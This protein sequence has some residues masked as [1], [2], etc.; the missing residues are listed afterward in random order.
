MFEFY[1]NDIANSLVLWRE[2][3]SLVNYGKNCKKNFY[4]A[5]VWAD[6][7]LTIIDFSLLLFNIERESVKM[8]TIFH[9]LS[10]LTYAKQTSS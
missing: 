6:L 3:K 10:K 2:K 9:V 5:L 4:F 7:I 1:K 8:S